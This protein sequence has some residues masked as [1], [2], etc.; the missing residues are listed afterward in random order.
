[1]AT[2]ANLYTHLKTLCMQWFYTKTE[3]DSSL[4]GKSDVGHTHE[5]MEI[6][7][8]YTNIETGTFILTTLDDVLEYNKPLTRINR[9]LEHM[10]ENWEDY[11]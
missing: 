1:M 7:S 2:L 4:D 9:A 8:S 6:N 5:D 3:I 10:I 11:D